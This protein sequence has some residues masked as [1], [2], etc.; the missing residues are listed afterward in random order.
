MNLLVKTKK[1]LPSQTDISC[2]YIYILP[3]PLYC[4]GLRSGLCGQAVHVKA[5]K[6]STHRSLLTNK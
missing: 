1:G 2:S 6:G 4:G 3:C 5:V